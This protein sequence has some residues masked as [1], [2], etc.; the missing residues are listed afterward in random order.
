[1]SQ[2]YT[3]LEKKNVPF[4][5][6]EGY[7]ALL[8]LHAAHADLEYSSQERAKILELVSEIQLQSLESFYNSHTDYQI[9]DL[10]IQDRI[11]F[12]YS[13]MI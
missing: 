11:N 6:K 4:N 1:M 7:T 8:M 9:L 5:D 13:A 2:T 10:L 3:D 12:G